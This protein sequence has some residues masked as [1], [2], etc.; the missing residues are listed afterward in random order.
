MNALIAVFPIYLFLFALYGRRDPKGFLLLTGIIAL[1]FPITYSFGSIPHRV[2]TGSIL[3]TLSDVSFVLLF[4]LLLS[5]GEL[6]LAPRPKLLFPLVCF[7]GACVLS[8]INSV[9]GTLSVNAIVMLSK[10]LLLHYFTV[11]RSIGSEADLRRVVLFLSISLFIQSFYACGQHLLGWQTDIF[12]TGQG[13]HDF[14][15]LESG[16][17]RSPGFLGRPNTLAEYIVPLLLL[18]LVLLANLKTRRAPR[19][20]LVVV[21]FL[22]LVFTFSRGGWLSFAVAAT[23]YFVVAYWK[24]V[25]K[26]KHL[27]GMLAVIAVLIVVLYPKIKERVT[28]YDDNAA[29]SRLPLIKNAH[30][31][32]KEHPFIGV[33][34]NTYKDVMK[35][36]LTPDI[37]GVY[38]DKVHNHFLLVFAETGVLGLV[39]F[40]WLMYTVFQ[41]ALACIQNKDSRLVHSL[42][43]ALL[44]SLLAV[45]VHMLVDTYCTDM[46]LGSFLILCSLCSAAR[47]LR[48]SSPCS[49]P[50]TTTCCRAIG[51][52]A[53]S[54]G[55]RR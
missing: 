50:P 7:I 34:V 44:L 37:Y 53:S 31:M 6:H 26:A 36:Y 5:R 41:E 1:P 46:S 17:I 29:I 28:A 48:A 40:L 20:I 52:L 10:L 9:A 55:A 30:N 54:P 11:A 47:D 14:V 43:T 24:R 4:F 25:I 19:L 33:G 13:A 35:D 8:M 49:P 32:I 21:S 39:A 15:M 18:N 38:L 3:I 42:G 12:R 2:W 51:P 27:V 16:A 45:S 23:A 22:A